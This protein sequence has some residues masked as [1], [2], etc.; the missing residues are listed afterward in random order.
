VKLPIIH[1]LVHTKSGILAFLAVVAVV[2]TIALAALGRFGASTGTSHIPVNQ[3]VKV[4]GVILS[5]DGDMVGIKDKKSGQFVIVNIN[6]NTKIERKKHRFLFPRQTDMDVTTMVPG[7]T[8]E[9]ELVRNPKGQLDAVKISFSPDQFAIKNAQEQQVAA[10][11]AEDAHG[12]AHRGTATA[13]RAQSSAGHAQ[14]S[15][16]QSGPQAQDVGPFESA[17]ATDVSMLNHR[18]SDLD[19]YKNEFEVDV[20][21]A[22]DSAM[23]N[24]KAKKDLDNLADIAKSLDGYMIEIAGY[25]SNTLGAEV[26]QRLSEDRAAAVARYFQEVKNV[27]MRRVLAPVGYGVTHPAVSNKDLRL[28]GLNDRVDIK[29]LV[30]KNLG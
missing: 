24:E 16:E 19:D 23:L 6:D 4:T 27:P 25:T 29:I 21:F 3:Q 22:G 8:I 18:V 2:S 13:G 1:T 14:N 30:N 12:T 17:D 20:F 26:D 11:K 15:A 7:L 10:N 9:A 5:R 28:R